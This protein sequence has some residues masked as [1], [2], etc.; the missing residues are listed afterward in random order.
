MLS[1]RF[2]CWMW[3]IQSVVFFILLLVFQLPPDWLEKVCSSFL[4]I[5]MAK[6]ISRWVFSW[7]MEAIHVK[8]SDKGVNVAMSEESGQNI[9][10]KFISIFDGELLPRRKPVN[11]LSVIRI[12]DI[13]ECTSSISYVFLI[14]SAILGSWLSFCMFSLIF[15]F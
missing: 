14:K 13:F 1:W 5:R 10:L 4:E 6:D 3:L 11:N 15:Y 12:L 2:H 8:L 7:L 9:C